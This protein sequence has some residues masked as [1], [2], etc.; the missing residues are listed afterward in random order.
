MVKDRG[1]W[2]VVEVIDV[3][4]TTLGHC[5][6]FNLVSHEFGAAGA[7]FCPV[8]DQVL[9]YPQHIV[10]NHRKVAELVKSLKR[11]LSGLPINV[12]IRMV[13]ATSW[14]GVFKCF[15]HRVRGQSAVIVNGRKVCDGDYAV[16][17]AVERIKAEAMNIL[18]AS[19]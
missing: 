3:Y 8:S 6:H 12:Q 2:V 15:R 7:E 1:R 13:D 14:V 5:P 16:D 9:E 11:E 4:P 18:S 19:T 10:S 17:E